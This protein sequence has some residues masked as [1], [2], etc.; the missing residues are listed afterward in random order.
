MLNVDDKRVKIACK[1]FLNLYRTKTM[2]QTLL[3]FAI[4]IITTG[5]I[6]Q[7]KSVNYGL[8]VGFNIGKIGISPP[9]QNRTEHYGA[10]LVAGGLT[11]IPILKKIK[12]QTEALYHLHNS[13][14][15][16]NPSSGGDV[17]EIDL[18]LHQI[19]LPVQLSYSIIPNVSLNAGVSANYN[20]Y[21]SQKV[22]RDFGTNPSFNISDEI[23]NFQSGVLG[24]ITIYASSF[25]IDARY[26]RMT[27][28][29]YNKRSTDDPT[30]YHLG[31]FQLSLGYRF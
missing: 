19:S 15:K 13:S 8:K 1:T 18:S 25:I 2:R 6:A 9:L 24:G 26:N 31:F 16:F 7:G 23:V 5:A 10:G 14:L 28:S 29:I 12:I 20:F 21:F 4:T 11:R 22:M 30:E 3:L 17:N 27:G